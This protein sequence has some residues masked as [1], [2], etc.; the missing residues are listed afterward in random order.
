[1]KIVTLDRE[2]IAKLIEQENVD[3]FIGVVETAYFEF[4]ERPY[5]PDNEHDVVSREKSRLE[6]LKDFSSI[7][8]SGGGYIVIGLVPGEDVTQF[9]LEYVNNLKGIE[10]EKI[11]LKGWLD[12]L[13]QYLVP[14]FQENFISHGFIGTDK[15]L[16]WIQIP[17]AKAIGCYPFIIAKDQWI[18]E[19]EKLLKGEL[20]GLYFRDGSKNRQLFSAEKF[21]E[22][23]AEVLGKK[24]SD[25][26]VQSS[27][28][29]AKIDRLL[30]LQEGTVASSPIDPEKEKKEIVQDFEDKLDQESDFFYMIAIPTEKAIIPEFWETAEESNLYNLIKKPPTLRNMGWDLNVAFSEYPKPSGEAWEIMNGNRKILQVNKTGTVAA[31]GTLQEFLDWGTKRDQETYKPLI[32]AFA[33]VEY[34]NMYCYFLK[35]FFSRFAKKEIKYTVIVG[36]KIRTGQKFVLH[37]TVGTFPSSAPK[38]LSKSEWVFDGID[39]AR[40][41][42]PKA[43]A[44]E[45]IREIYASG[46]GSVEEFPHYLKKTGESWEVEEELYNKR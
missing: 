4:R 32:N 33:L 24:N 8:N 46:F 40:L 31:A 36:F 7:A 17:D 19:N 29:E 18:T 28:L 39:E 30:A 45:I 34:I 42:V 5:F 10:S 43:F 9:N 16:F 2:D 13:S 38:P 44:G 15:K 3:G 41:A 14:R 21:Q 11:N 20:Y 37:F 12:I 1:M 25:G 26:T 23:L 22:R 27:A 6:L 35:E